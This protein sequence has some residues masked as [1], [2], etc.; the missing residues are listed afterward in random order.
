MPTPLLSLLVALLPAPALAGAAWNSAL[1]QDAI[2]GGEI[3][4][5]R[6]GLVRSTVQINII[7]EGADGRQGFLCSGT[8]IG[9]R[10]VLTVAHCLRATGRE[11]VEVAVIF[12]GNGERIPAESWRTHPDYF[13][14]SGR[15]NRPFEMTNDIALVKIAKPAPDWAEPASLPVGNLRPGYTYDFLIAGYG[16]VGD[17]TVS[18]DLL[19]QG[20]SR[21]ALKGERKISLTAGAFSCRG[22]SGGPAFVEREGKPELAGIISHGPESCRG[23]STLTSV[24]YYL[25]WIRDTALEPARAR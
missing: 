21:G 16:Q 3:V 13:Y 8:L 9:E 10:L 2:Y 24:G 6:T 4:A 22:D 17:G 19:R 15:E 5:S 1:A 20:R 14:S 12:E 25:D 23:D 11:V 18:F 7:S